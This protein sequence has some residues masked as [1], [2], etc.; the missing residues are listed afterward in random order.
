MAILLRFCCELC[1]KEHQALYFFDYYY[2]EKINTQ[3]WKKTNVEVTQLT[4]GVSYQEHCFAFN[5][6]KLMIEMTCAVVN[7]NLIQVC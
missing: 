1:V 3:I 7:N 5:I 4:A 6:E 2:G